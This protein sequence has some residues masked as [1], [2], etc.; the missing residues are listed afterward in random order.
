V[1]VSGTVSQTVF[2]TRKVV[3]HA[4]RRCRLPPEGVGS[5]QLTV[6]LESLY[7]ILSQLANRGLQLWCIER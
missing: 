2:N 1:A 7:L 4:F 3:D 6:A 5:E